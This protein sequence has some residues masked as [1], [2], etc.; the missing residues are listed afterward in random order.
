MSYLAAKPVDRSATKPIYLIVAKD[1]TVKGKLQYY[2][3][4][5]LTEKPATIEFRGWLL[6]K[7]QADQVTE[8]PNAKECVGTEV[9]R[10][11]PWHNVER[12]D[13]IKVKKA[14]GDSNV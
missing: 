14:Q 5:S 10:T 1:L 4:I 11:I 12:I 13:N 9:I 8:N 6:T 3:A 7:A 2:K